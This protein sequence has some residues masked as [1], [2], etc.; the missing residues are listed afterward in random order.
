MPLTS[1]DWTAVIPLRAGSK[2]LPGKNTRLLAGKPL[3]R[4]AVDEALAAGARR[5]VITTDIAEVLQAQQPA[6]VTLI[7]RPADLARDDVPMAPVLAHAIQSAGV[8]GTV[9]LLQATSPLRRASDIRAALAVFANGAHELVMSV[10]P[11]DRGVLKWGILDGDRF[12]PVSDPAYCF[13]NRQS[14][15]PVVR[16]NG[17]VYVVDAAGFVTRG[18]FVTDRIGLIEMSAERS[19]DIDNLQDFERCAAVLSGMSKEPSMET[20][21]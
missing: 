20:R 1:P 19:Q 8:L 4:H 5:V 11:A 7:P 18:S 13:S 12:R 9:V 10:T 17:A 14:L 16:P 21:T 2:G 6:G 3:Y 15:P